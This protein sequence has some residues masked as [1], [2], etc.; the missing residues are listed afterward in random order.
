ME[1]DPDVCVCVGGEGIWAVETIHSYICVYGSHFAR[2]MWHREI[3]N[4]ALQYQ[5]HNYCTVHTLHNYELYHWI[6]WILFKLRYILQSISRELKNVASV[7][8]NCTHRTVYTCRQF[9]VH[10][11][12]FAHMILTTCD[13]NNNQKWSIT[14]I[15]LTAD[16]A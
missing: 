14:V 11:N 2:I 9:T 1:Y 16:G 3:W 13:Q 8:T 10:M 12:C 6:S 4:P 15:Y 7:S 5:K